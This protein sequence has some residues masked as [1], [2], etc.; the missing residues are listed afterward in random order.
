[1]PAP[2]ASALAEPAATPR[3]RA[4]S[5]DAPSM[6]AS[7]KA[8]LKES[9]DPTAL[10]AWNVR[11]RD[12]PAP[13]GIGRPDLARTIGHDGQEGPTLDER[14]GGGHRVA[15]G[16]HEARL[17]DLVQADLDDVRLRAQGDQQPLA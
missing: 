7:E 8:A 15:L 14:V 16:L 17:D 11:H 9:P 1:M 4:V 2:S 10:T 5:S 13:L 12:P 6:S 3:A